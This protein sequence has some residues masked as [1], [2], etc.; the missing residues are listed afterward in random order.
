MEFSTI[1]PC[2][3]QERQPSM[4]LAIDPLHVAY[5]ANILLLGIP[6]LTLV[7]IWRLWH[8]ELDGHGAIFWGVMILFVPLFGPLAFLAAR[9]GRRRST[10][11]PQ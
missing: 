4:A 3:S 6:L 10:V 5:A 8:T 7:A 1:F 9:P 11:T 2:S